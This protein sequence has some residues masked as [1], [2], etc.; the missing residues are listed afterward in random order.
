MLIFRVL[1]GLCILLSPAH[2][3]ATSGDPAVAAQQYCSL[4]LCLNTSGP[5]LKYHFTFI[6][7]VMQRALINLLI[8]L[9]T[10]CVAVSIGK[11]DVCFL[12]LKKAWCAQ[13]SPEEP[14]VPFPT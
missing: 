4:M 12:L 1:S 13:Q 6:Y 5:F 7:A 2:L 3:Q 11:A 9:T 14:H 8:P 10:Y